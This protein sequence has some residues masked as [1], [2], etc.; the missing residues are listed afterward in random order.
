MLSKINTKTKHYFGFF[1]LVLSVV[2]VHYSTVHFGGNLFPGSPIEAL[3]D[4]VALVLC[5]SGFLH[6]HT[7]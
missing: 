5:L 1:C 6:T 3:F 2:F 4:F 7:K